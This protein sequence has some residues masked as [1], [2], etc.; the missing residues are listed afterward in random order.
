MK[1]VLNKNRSPDL[2]L[3]DRYG[4]ASDIWAVGCIMGELYDGKP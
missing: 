4:K 2:L 3:T 1:I